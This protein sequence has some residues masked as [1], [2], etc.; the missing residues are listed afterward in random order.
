MK[1]DAYVGRIWNIHATDTY[2]CTFGFCLAPTGDYICELDVL[3]RE[4]SSI[5]R[6]DI[7][8]YK[9]AFPLALAGIAYEMVSLF[10]S[11]HMEYS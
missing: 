7:C 11:E 1:L 9:F 6:S 4:I 5:Q 2:W 10:I 3:I 8:L